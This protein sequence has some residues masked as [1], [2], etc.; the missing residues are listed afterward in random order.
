MLFFHDKGKVV[1]TEMVCQCY[2]SVSVIG[3]FNKEAMV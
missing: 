1:N 3:E 2:R